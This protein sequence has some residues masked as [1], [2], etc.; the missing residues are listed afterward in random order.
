MKNF[1]NNEKSMKNL[2]LKIYI[3]HFIA[4]KLHFG[5]VGQ[6]REVIGNFE[7][8]LKRFLK[9]M[10]KMHYFCIFSKDLTNHA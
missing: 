5:A 1:T 7:K 10:A 8:I 4:P 6:Q 2:N 9:K 3:L